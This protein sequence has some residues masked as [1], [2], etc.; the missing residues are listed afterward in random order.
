MLVS[1][2]IDAHIEKIRKAVDGCGCAVV[3]APPGSGKTTRVPP[4]LLD[5][6]PL[7]LLQPRRMAARALARRIAFERNWTVGGEVGWQVRHERRFGRNTRLLVA[8]E[9]I[10]T[11]RLIDDPLLSGFATVVLDEF[12]AEIS[13]TGQ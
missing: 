8:T 6:G 7:L 12:H 5:P 13:R 4:A 1:L 10:L 2:P 11:T 9:G 3:V